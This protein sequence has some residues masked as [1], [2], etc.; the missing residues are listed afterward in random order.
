M[1]ANVLLNAGLGAKE[2]D[3]GHIV[4]S[5]LPSGPSI[6]LDLGACANLLDMLCGNGCD[7]LMDCQQELGRYQQQRQAKPAPLQ[8]DP[9][10]TLGAVGDDDRELWGIWLTDEGRWL[11]VPSEIETPAG[12]IRYGY[13]FAIAF[14]AA[15][16]ATKAGHPAEARDIKAW[17]REVLGDE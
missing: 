16:N 17:V 12:L 10:M 8:A 13:S 6:S 9:A 5:T 11:E 7:A 4:I 1:M 14:A 3:N 15:H 2:L